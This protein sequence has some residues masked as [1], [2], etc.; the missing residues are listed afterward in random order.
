M[1]YV[2]AFVG[3]IGISLATLSWHLSNPPVPT[4]LDS[5]LSSDFRSADLLY[6]RLLSND[7]LL[8]RANEPGFKGIWAV[9]QSN[10]SPNDISVK[11]I[12]I[13][14]AETGVAFG[15]TAHN[16]TTIEITILTTSGEE[17]AILL[18]DIKEQMREKLLTSRVDSLRRA[19]LWF[20]VFCGLFGVIGPLISKKYFRQ[21]SMKTN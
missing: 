11:A 17:A 21:L 8:V 10:L 7:G 6:E 13:D 5:R 12:G 1:K 2:F 20:G 15:R 18:P 9:I 3:V 4:F 14:I 16:Y 19:L